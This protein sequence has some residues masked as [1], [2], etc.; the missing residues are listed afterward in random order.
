MGP[1]ETH[2][3]AHHLS[4]AVG[5]NRELSQGFHLRLDRQ[6]AVLGDLQISRESHHRFGGN[7]VP[8]LIVKV[9][10][11]AHALAFRD[12]PSKSSASLSNPGSAKVV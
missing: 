9:E 8:L 5:R 11:A 1:S 6:A 4:L 7:G 3:S 2:R 10:G 12:T